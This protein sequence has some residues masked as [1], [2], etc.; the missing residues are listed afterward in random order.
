MS[1]DRQVR[2]GNLLYDPEEEADPLGRLDG[3]GDPA[4]GYLFRVYT[5][6]RFDDGTEN[7]CVLWFVDDGRRL[8]TRWWPLDD[9][10]AA[11][12][13][14]VAADG[15]VNFEEDTAPFTLDEDGRTVTVT[16]AVNPDIEDRPEATQWF[17]VALTGRNTSFG[18]PSTVCDDIP[19]DMEA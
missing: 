14:R 18:Y 12:P 2:S 10:E 13:W 7:R 3:S 17:R 5:Q 9:V 15:I 1:V 4:T 11:T 19:E 16:L 8:L 6:A